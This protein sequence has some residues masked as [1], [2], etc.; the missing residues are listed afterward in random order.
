MSTLASAELPSDDDSDTDFVPVAPAKSK[1]KSKGKRRR[2]SDESGSGSGS[3]SDDDAVDE[4][5]K[6]HKLDLEAAGTEERKRKAAEAFRAMQAEVVGGPREVK[7]E[8]EM[9]EVRRARRF[10][11]ETI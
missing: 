8:V 5:A 9:V 11:G 10:A 3:S 4:E 6:R 1:S 2:S 7:A